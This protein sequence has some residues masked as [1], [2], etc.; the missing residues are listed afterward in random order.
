MRANNGI[1]APEA[2]GAG[3]ES[4]VDALQSI[5]MYYTACVLATLM[6]KRRE[7]NCGRGEFQLQG[8]TLSFSAL[9]DSHVTVCYFQPGRFVP[10]LNLTKLQL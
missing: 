9:V 6:K 4:V 3:A 10:N 1:C 5:N 8:A 7:K 2:A